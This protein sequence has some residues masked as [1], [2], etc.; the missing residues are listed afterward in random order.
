VPNINVVGDDH[1]GK[2][3]GLGQAKRKVAAKR[4]TRRKRLELIDFVLH[5]RRIEE[6]K[7]IR[8]ILRDKGVCDCREAV[9]HN[10]RDHHQA[11]LLAKHA[12]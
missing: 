10:K 6:H 11:P 4:F 8:L 1:A 9:E 7:R 5:R 3:G 2:L 12:R